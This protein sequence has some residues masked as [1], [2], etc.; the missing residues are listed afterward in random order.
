MSTGRGRMSLTGQVAALSLVAIL[1]LGFALTRVL[2]Q[3]VMS[4]ALSNATES[5]QLIARIGVQP[6]LT[7]RDLRQGLIPQ[8]VHN[9]DEQLSG[10]SASRDLARIKI[11]NTHHEVIYSD[12]HALIDR[13]LAPSD[14]LVNALAGNPHAAE[15]VTPSPHTE[16]ASEV[17][18]GKLVEVYVP[19]RFRAST[20][21]AGVFEIYLSY[22]PIGSAI[23]HEQRLI[24]IV[25][26][27]GLALLWGVLYR[28]AARASRTLRHQVQENDHLARYDRLTGLP[29]RTLFL[30]RVGE[31]LRDDEGPPHLAVLLV[32]LDGFKEINDTLGHQ[33]GDALLRETANRFAKVNIQDSFAARLDGDEY[34][35][36]LSTCSDQTDVLTA[37]RVIQSTLQKPVTL[38]GVALNIETS[39]GIATSTEAHIS[40]VELLRR[41]D[42]AL[43]RAK[44]LHSRVEVYASSLN[45]FSAQR[46]ALLGRV[47]PALEHK[48]FVLHYQPQADLKSA[49]ITGVEALLRWEHPQRG[50]LGPMEFIPMTERTALIGPVTRFVIDQAL[51]QIRT[52]Q[53]S[54]L[55]MALSVNLSTR[56]L[57]D[58]DLPAD[59]QALLEKHE[60]PAS[61]LTLEVTESAALTNPQR[62]I[63]TLNAL[64]ALGVRISI[65]DFGTGHA[66]IAYLTSMPLDEIKIDR[67]LIAGVEREQRGRAIV[68][69]TIDLATNLALHIVVEGIETRSAWD[70]LERLGAHTGQGYFIERPLSALDLEAWLSSLRVHS[71]STSYSLSL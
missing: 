35:L 59:V 46:L 65:D 9:L 69:S 15:V 7:P 68:Q 5:A 2:Q 31:A 58:A 47:R 6:L 11:W 51:S 64:R 16:T 44:L 29:N 71:P 61:Q 45:T 52:W 28:I 48:E 12:D 34:A 19:L 30:E 21:P 27:A 23:A 13:T 8:E 26:F 22:R 62:A 53:R 18:L 10:R 4:S 33:T 40:P 43:D 1:I 38:D 14:D 24:V 20:K 56:N 50:L 17:G 39:I 70:A 37:A 42:V 66:S 67:S 36:L 57:T 54:G 63:Q 49:E 60:L 25:V 3:Q 41:A 32:D 55:S